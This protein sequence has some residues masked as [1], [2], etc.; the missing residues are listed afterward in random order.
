MKSI[1]DI[2]S[3]VY[4]DSIG[5]VTKSRWVGSFQVKAIISNADRLAKARLYA[6]LMPPEG[7]SVEEDDKIRAELIAQLSVR[8]VSGPEFWSS[9]YGGQ[10]LTDIDPL[11]D[12]LKLCQ[13]ATEN[14]NKQLNETAQTQDGNVIV[15]PKV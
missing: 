15:E 4:L 12:L 7:S 13:E 14:W 2:I 11:V 1:P 5:E 8:V 10:L 3:T 6:K 9:S